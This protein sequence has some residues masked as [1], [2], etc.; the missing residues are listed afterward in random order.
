MIPELAWAFAT[1]LAGSLH[2]LGMCGPLVV[3]YSLNL[4]P[5]MRSGLPAQDI[6]WSSNLTHHL[7]FHLGR[8]ATYGFLGALGAGIVRVGGFSGSLLG[9]RSIATLA[10]GVLMVLFGLVLLKV[11]PM[12]P[13]ISQGPSRQKETILNR[14]IRTNLVS[15]RPGSGWILGLAAGFLPCMLSWAVIIKA[16]TTGSIS[17]GFLLMVLFGLGTVPALFFTGFSA[18]L[19]SLRMRLAGERVAAVS[20]VVMGLILLLK[21]VSRLV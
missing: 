7:T 18:S 2:C 14:L 19:F 21:G 6:Y 20:V 15:R 10:G 11:V 17:T 4:R 8:M 16:A 3:A 13:L 5:D 12:L 1:G 9:L